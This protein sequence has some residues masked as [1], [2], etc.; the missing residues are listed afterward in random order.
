MPKDYYDLTIK[1][2]IN[3]K[4]K[5]IDTVRDSRIYAS[6]RLE[7]YAKQWNF[8]FLLLNILAVVFVITSL[9]DIAD[10]NFLIIT[11]CYT[12]YV[13]LL[14][15]FISLQ[16][17]NERALRF[18]YHQLE[19]EKSIIDLKI[20]L[21]KYRKFG[22]AKLIQEYKQVIKEYSLNLTNSENHIDSDFIYAKDKKLTF[23]EKINLDVF[24]VIM[25]YIILIVL[26]MFYVWFLFN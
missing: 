4:I 9:T 15:Y 8:L 10:K 22:E 18:H 14:Q 25:N 1:Q 7:N 26:I 23:V 11:S 12:L 5:S 6:K 20:I 21:I 17:Y 13:I 3:K 19:L 16:N 24:V 2:E